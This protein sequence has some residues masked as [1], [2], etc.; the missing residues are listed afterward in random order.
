MGFGEGTISLQEQD[1]FLVSF[2]SFFVSN[3]AAGRGG[4]R[5]IKKISGSVELSMTMQGLFL[6]FSFFSWRWSWCQTTLSKTNVSI[7]EFFE[8]MQ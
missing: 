3:T 7:V 5:M 1:G 8:K 4:V 2:R 6:F